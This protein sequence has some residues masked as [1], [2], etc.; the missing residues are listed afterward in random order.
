MQKKLI[1]LAIAGLA[2]TAAFAADNV[3]VYGRMDFGYMHRSGDS[4]GV[5]NANSKG[6]FT[7][8]GQGGSRIGFKGSEA[9]G[10]GLTL[11]FESEYG[12]AIDST[13]GTLNLAT[14]AA[15][16][17]AATWNNRHSYIG[18]TGAFGT[19][20]GGRLDGIR[21]GMF[22]K[23]DPF[24]NGT[25]ANM[26][27]ISKGQLDRADNAIAYISPTWNGFTGTL[28]YATSVVG[29]EGTSVG[30][31]GGAGTST[32]NHN[33]LGLKSFMVN[34][35]N[36]PLD[37]TLDHER[38]DSRSSNNGLDIDGVRVTVL[39]ASYDFGMVKLSALYDRHTVDLNGPRVIDDRTWFVGAK[40]PFA[41]KFVGKV[42]YGR[43]DDRENNN[44]DSSKWGIGLDYNLSK[45]TN[46]YVNYGSINNDRNSITAI[47]NA[48]N[49]YNQVTSATTGALAGQQ[50]GT[51]GMDIGIA[52]NF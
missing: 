41:G 29:Q 51:R 40:V 26:T 10:N 19:A 20:V 34:Y 1:A 3:T 2:S 32:G 17:Q 33:D 28:A 12:I 9:L 50:V 14:A 35:A 13:P 43:N 46:L 47:S 36:G 16:S 30:Y 5:N 7:S 21:Y 4:G 23:Y 42:A 22:G 48:A 39:A 24:G 45:R 6:E 38:V 11:I 8:G 15:G 44:A 52:H 25:I 18:L 31:T 37:V 27:Q 49:A